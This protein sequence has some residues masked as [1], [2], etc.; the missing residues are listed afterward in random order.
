[1]PIYRCEGSITYEGTHDIEADSEQEAR[2]EF[3]EILCT[4]G[5]PE[6]DFKIEILE[7]ERNQRKK[8]T[9]C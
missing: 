9:D 5:F 8:T 2:A 4:G 6:C 3:E 7:Q 1:M